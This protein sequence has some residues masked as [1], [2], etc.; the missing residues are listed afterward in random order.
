VSPAASPQQLDDP[1]QI[2]DVSDLRWEDLVSEAAGDTTV[3][4]AFYTSSY[5]DGCTT[6]TTSGSEKTFL[7]SV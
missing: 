3:P 7:C 6:T 5:C 2:E 4:Q 1:L